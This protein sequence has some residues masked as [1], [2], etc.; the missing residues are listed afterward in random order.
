M[1]AYCECCPFVNEVDEIP[2]SW[3][4]RND[5]DTPAQL[6]M[7]MEVIDVASSRQERLLKRESAAWLQDCVEYILN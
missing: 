5:T 7:R 2:V 4:T 6:E 3:A 1:K